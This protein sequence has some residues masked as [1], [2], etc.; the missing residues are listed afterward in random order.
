MSIRKWEIA[1]THNGTPGTT[2]YKSQFE[3]T[4]KVALIHVRKNCIPDENV[5][6]IREG[7]K[8][9]PFYK[10]HYGLALSGITAL[11]PK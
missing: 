9:F 1:Y 3:P 4:R 2:V 10:K 5:I 8:F 7:G 6:A 11:T